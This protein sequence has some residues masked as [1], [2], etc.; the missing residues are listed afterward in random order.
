MD[1]LDRRILNS[2][3]FGFP[4]TTRPYLSIGR[5][6]GCGEAEVLDRIGSLKKR[7]IVRQI[8]P[9]FDSARLGYRSTLAAFVV[10]ENKVDEVAALLN[11]HAGVTHNYLRE[12]TVNLW[13]TLTVPSSQDIRDHIRTMAKAAHVRRWFFLPTIKTFKI[14]F[15]LDM[16]RKS[17]GSA[18]KARNRAAEG[19]HSSPP[20][21]INRDFVRI[22]QRDLPLCSRPY[23]RAARELGM[24]EGRVVATLRRYIRAKVIRRVAS[25]LRP[26]NAGYTANVMVAWAA[27]GKARRER[28]G[29]CAA[30]NTL[31]S[32]CYQ[33]PSSR[34]WP[35][36]MYTMIH[37]RSMRECRRVI[38]DIAKCSGVTDYR[39]L[40]TRKEYKKV[41]ALYFMEDDSSAG[42]AHH[43][44]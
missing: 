25:V 14:S 13:F 7:R 31:V 27:R 22:V 4:L 37:G 35:Y 41:R 16:S 24:S 11:G 18:G 1:S 33:R 2:L 39:A 36:S 9:I 28:L 17:D 12:G 44:G 10:P 38:G 15:R 30:A 20:V 40:V 29:L 34:A 5:S 42:G 43:H 19:G 23:R 21:R 8:S 32:H 6:V 26:N 3:Q